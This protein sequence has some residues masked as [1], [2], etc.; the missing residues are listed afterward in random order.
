MGNALFVRDAAMCAAPTKTGTDGGHRRRTTGSH[1]K[2]RNRAVSLPGI[3]AA[4]IILALPVLVVHSSAVRSL[5]YAAWIMPLAELAL[6]AFGQLN[7]RYRYREAPDKF[8][9]LI[10][11]ITT[12]GAEYDRVSEIIDEI[13]DYPL[14]MDYQIWVVT[15]P[16]M[17]ADYP[18]A[19]RVLVVPAEF[20][21]RAR[22]KA[23]AL[24]Y[25]RRVR[26]AEGLARPDVKVLFVDD[27]VSLTQGYIERSFNADYDLCQGIITPR[28]AYGL[29]PFAHFA[30]SHADDIRT[31]S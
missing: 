7:F 27:D 25:G 26:L 20:S 15:E 28:T 24:E 2:K 6:L 21:C 13:R 3:P 12:T 5:V 10:I 22:K 11:Q 16:G 31:H 29:R 8:G 30:A 4:L 18:F 1:R 9:E 14:K 19:D 17:P 23:R